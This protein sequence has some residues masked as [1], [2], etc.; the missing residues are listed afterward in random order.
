M[1]DDPVEPQA[2]VLE[3]EDFSFPCNSP[4]SIDSPSWLYPPTSLGDDVQSRVK[5]KEVEEKEEV[6]RDPVRDG[7]REDKMDML[8]EDFNEELWGSSSTGEKRG[9]ESFGGGKT[10]SSKGSGRGGAVSFPAKSPGAM[11]LAKAL[12]KIFLLRG[13][14]RRLSWLDQAATASRKAVIP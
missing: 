2:P 3:E 9:R 13:G 11:A 7:S 8:W 5:Q 4:C 14:H 1:A 12:R 6:V 10:G